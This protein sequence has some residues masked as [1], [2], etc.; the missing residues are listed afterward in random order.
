M[1][2]CLFEDSVSRNFLPL[3]WF[4]PV[5]DLRCGMLSLRERAL[6]FL[7]PKK[8]SLHAQTRLAALLSEHE[9]NAEINSISSES[10][11][12]LNGRCIVDKDLVKAIKKER[13]ECVFVSGGEIVAARIGGVALRRLNVELKNGLTDFSVFTSLPRVD[14]N[15]ILVKYPWDLVYANDATLISDFALLNRKSRTSQVKIHKSVVLLGRKNIH[16]GA[17]AHISAAVVLDAQAGPIVLG[18]DAYIHPQAVIE[19]PCFVGAGSIIK[20]GAKIYG[21]TSIGASCKVGGEVEH[22][23][24]HSHSNK[25]HDGYLGHSYI[26]QWVNLGAGTTT[27]NLK[28]TYGSVSVDMNGVTIDS[29]RMFLGTLSGDHVKTGI[30][31]SLATGTVIGPSTNIFGA[32]LFPKRL[33]AFSWGESGSL[34]VYSLEKALEVAVKVMARRDVQATSGYRQVFR[35]VFQQTA[36]ERTSRR[37]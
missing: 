34:T 29:G 37:T 22:S 16:L 6:I 12:V 4:R 11:L 8:I 18:K 17:R 5:Y 20:I 30:N 3:T 24:I 28:N 23:I 9:P 15:A 2:L 7:S 27:S 13:R 36:Y 33:P 21:N 35:E 31:V 14:V 19:G 32:A 1:H 10:C 26:G 25:Q